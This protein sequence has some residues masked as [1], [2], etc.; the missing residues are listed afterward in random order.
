MVI[1]I[2]IVIINICQFIVVKVKMVITSVWNEHITN[3]R[4]YSKVD[5]IL[6]RRQ[7]RWPIIKLVLC[8]R[9]VFPEKLS[10]QETDQ[11]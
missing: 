10:S 5:L 3:T 4:H 7:R 1:E 11:R 2:V 8:Q 9:L 6:G